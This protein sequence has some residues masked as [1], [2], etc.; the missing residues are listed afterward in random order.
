M[1]EAINMGTGVRNQSTFPEADRRQRREPRLGCFLTT[2]QVRRILRMNTHI[3]LRSQEYRQRVR[4]QCAQCHGRNR[5][6]IRTCSAICEPV[7]MFVQLDEYNTGVFRVIGLSIAGARIRSGDVDGKWTVAVHLYLT[8]RCSAAGSQRGEPYAYL[9]MH[10]DDK[11]D[12]RDEKTDRLGANY[13]NPVR[14]RLQ[15]GNLRPRYA[16]DRLSLIGLNPPRLE[17]LRPRKGPEGS[18]RNSMN[19]TPP[20]CHFNHPKGCLQAN[21]TTS[22]LPDTF[23][24]CHGNRWHPTVS[25]V[26]RRS[27]ARVTS[28]PSAFLMASGPPSVAP[29]TP[30]GHQ[31]VKQ[32]SGSAIDYRATRLT[33][34]SVRIETEFAGN[35]APSAASGVALPAGMGESQPQ[36]HH[37]A[38]FIH[39]PLL[40]R[41]SQVCQF[42]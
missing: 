27:M 17:L 2:R 18:I 16:G 32:M 15:F 28:H 20:V 33:G 6:G 42:R 39:F 14:T 7:C 29:A 9:D 22:D 8:C 5:T 31:D 23:I 30:R 10:I 34:F 19:G 4:L 24:G 21:V 41:V 40:R 3:R 35:C 13:L 12:S 25:P 11:T 37:H 36:Y 26:P 38:C 1:P